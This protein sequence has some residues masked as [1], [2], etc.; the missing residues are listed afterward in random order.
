M[1]AA[2]KLRALNDDVGAM[3]RDILSGTADA[4]FGGD[5]YLRFA[6]LG[7]ALPQIVAVV[8]AAEQIANDG[9]LTEQHRRQIAGD[10][11]AALEEALL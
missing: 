3:S 8:E 2:E 10:A 6:E 11:L 4:E 5:W 1:S 7:V 9:Y